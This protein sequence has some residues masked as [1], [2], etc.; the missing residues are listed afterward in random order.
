[1]HAGQKGEFHP[2]DEPA[3]PAEEVKAEPSQGTPVPDQSQ[4]SGGNRFKKKAEQF[5]PSQS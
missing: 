2:T 5:T 1:L 4:K 3:Q